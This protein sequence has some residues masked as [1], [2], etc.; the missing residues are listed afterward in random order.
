LAKREASHVSINLTPYAQG[1]IRGEGCAAQRA[2]DMFFSV[3]TAG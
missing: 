1:S 3:K 2:K